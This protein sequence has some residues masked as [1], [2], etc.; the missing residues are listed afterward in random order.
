MCEDNIK[1]S[2]IQGI[3]VV[4]MSIVIIWVVTPCSLVRLHSITT[5]D[6]YRNIKMD[7]KEICSESID[8]TDLVQYRD[9]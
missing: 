7:L 4:K 6:H 1:M 9:Q 3:T 2:E 8:L 5:T